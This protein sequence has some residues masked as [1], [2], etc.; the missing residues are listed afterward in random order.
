MQKDT[1]GF[2]T[3]C[4]HCG[5]ETDIDWARPLHLCQVCGIAFCKKCGINYVCKSCLIREPE[6]VQELLIKKARNILMGKVKGLLSF[7]G[8]LALLIVFL[9]SF[10][11]FFQGN[12]AIWGI[13][14]FFGG[15]SFFGGYSIKFMWHRHGKMV[16]LINQC[17]FEK[18]T[19]QLNFKGLTPRAE[20][21]QVPDST[22]QSPSIIQP[23]TFNTFE[24]PPLPPPPS[25]TEMICLR[26]GGRV[27]ANIC[28]TCHAKICPKCGYPDPNNNAKLCELCDYVF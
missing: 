14:I 28:Q 19:D 21:I 3:P 20:F 18:D 4:V 11:S 10:G 22:P 27:K 16:R 1:N 2:S 26:C 13:I 15:I 23:Q 6:N 17:Y 24:T 8:G 12:N 7:F 9:I 25:P 5:R